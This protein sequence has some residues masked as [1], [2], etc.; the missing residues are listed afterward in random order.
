MLAYQI[1]AG[2]LEI[3]IELRKK[4]NISKKLVDLYLWVSNEDNLLCVHDYED[5]KKCMTLAIYNKTRDE[6]AICFKGALGRR[7]IE[8]VI[9]PDKVLRRDPREILPIYRYGKIS[10][11]SRN[12]TYHRH[13]E[14]P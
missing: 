6:W 7:V 10:C 14:I 13:Y 8:Y 11:P 5:H 2:F 4:E 9:N 12:P 3:K 1:V